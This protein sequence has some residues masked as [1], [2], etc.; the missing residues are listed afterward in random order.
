MCFKYMTA[1]LLI[2]LSQSHLKFAVFTNTK[3]SQHVVYSCR[4]G[5]QVHHHTHTSVAPG[6]LGRKASACAE[7]SVCCA[8]G[9]KLSLSNS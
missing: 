3:Q 9:G 4:V 1:V 6:R 5:G 8:A 2:N 7:S